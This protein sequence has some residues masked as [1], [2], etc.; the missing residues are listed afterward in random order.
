MTPFWLAGQPLHVLEADAAPHQFL[1][2]G[3]RHRVTAISAHWRVHTS[4]W[5]AEAIWRDYWEVTTDAGFL[6]VLFREVEIDG[7]FMERVWE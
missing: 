5:H 1:W 7:W 2:R 3:R 4:W 6:C